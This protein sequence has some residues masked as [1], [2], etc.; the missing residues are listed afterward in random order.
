MKIEARLDPDESLIILGD[1]RLIAVPKSGAATIDWAD[2]PR[3]ARAIHHCVMTHALGPGGER[4]VYVER[5][6]KQ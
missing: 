4:F 6:R 2:Y 5:P 1:G 3:G